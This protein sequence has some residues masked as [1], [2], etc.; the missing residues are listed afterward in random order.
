MPLIQDRKTKHYEPHIQIKGETIK[1]NAG[2]NKGIYREIIERFVSQLDIALCIHKR[3][4][5]LRFDLHL[6]KYSKDNKVIS[7][8]MNRLKQW[9]N[10]NYGLQNVGYIWVR[11]QEKS[12]RQHYHLALM[13]DENKIRHPKRL[14]AQIKEMWL[15]YGH[16]PT[17]KKPYFNINTIKANYKTV[18]EEIILRVSYLAKV[19]GKRYRD[20]QTKDYQTSR[21]N[22]VN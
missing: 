15:P 14:N 2:V 10:R 19:R 12:K 1:V 4:L 22:K 3:L 5:V 6:N 18:R 11:E 9:L 17:V 20:V 8:F 21:L 7:R 16:M 13:L